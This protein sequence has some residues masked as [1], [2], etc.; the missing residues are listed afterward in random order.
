VRIIAPE[1]LI[2]ASGLVR[3]QALLLD[4]GRIVGRGQARIL[5]RTHPDAQV[6]PLPG[7]A[8]MP[9][10]V[11]AHSHSF[12]SPLRG[13][14]SDRP[15]REWR[16]AL[17]QLTPSFTEEDIYA[18]A[19]HAFAEMALAGITTVVDF[20]YLHHGSNAGALAV[21]RAA[22]EVGLRLVL[23]RCMYDDPRAPA[24][25]RESVDGAVRNAR[26]LAAQLQGDDLITVIPAPHSPHGASAAMIQAGAL[27]ARE[28]GTPWHMHLAENASEGTFTRSRYGKT[29]VG[30]LSHIGAL[31]ERL[32]VVHG[33]YVA[34]D[35]IRQLVGAGVGLIHCPG[36]NLSLGDG[37][38]PV[39][40]YS[41]A[42]A[43]VGLGCDSASSTGRLSIFAEMRLAALLQKGIA[44]AADATAASA[45]FA[46]G[47]SG[48][49]SAT[50]LAIGGLATGSRADLVGLDLS[51]LSLLPAHDLLTNIVYSMR[52]GAIR[53]V[54]VNGEAVVREGTLVRVGAAAVAAGLAK[55]IARH[56]GSGRDGRARSAP[57]EAGQWPADPS[58]LDVN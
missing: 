42:G 23:A 2:D 27:L 15:F 17:Y 37:I 40:R 14:A 44:T 43:V 11:N 22:R 55:V 58:K 47:T 56:A 18:A 16:A 50:G 39:G 49:G 7:C 12:Q 36:A 26:S 29:P 52:S 10:T 9:G 4:G 32:K 30:W 5:A 24:A 48:G 34:D 19:L 41:S 33:V 28:W 54:F 13:L 46:M 45:V 57:P 31:D 1:L 35:E 6:E 51:D 21:V 20:F 3:D 38:C 53:Y 8:I 25:F